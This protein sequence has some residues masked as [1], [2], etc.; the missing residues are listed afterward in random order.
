MIDLRF[1]LLKSVFGYGSLLLFSQNRCTK[2][3][4]IW[5]DNSV[6]KALWRLGSCSLRMLWL[7]HDARKRILANSTKVAPRLSPFN[8]IIW[9]SGTSVPEARFPVHI[10][11]PQHVK[12]IRTPQQ[13][14]CFWCSTFIMLLLATISLLLLVTFHLFHHF[15]AVRKVRRTTLV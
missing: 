9:T 15:F 5:G 7:P 14:N 8:M 10:L 6:Q 3:C 13:V 12:Y 11:R 4:P 1:L 2:S